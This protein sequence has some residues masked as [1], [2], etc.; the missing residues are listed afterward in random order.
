MTYK[1]IVAHTINGVIGKAGTMPW[2]LPTD[3]AYFRRVTEGNVVVMGRKTF[4]S[5]GRPLPNRRNIVMTRSPQFQGE[6]IETVHGEEELEALLAPV[7]AKQSV[8][9][10]GG[11]TIYARFIDE[12]S[13]IHLTLIEAVID[14]DAFFPRLRGDWRVQRVEHHQTKPDRPLRGPWYPHCIYRLTRA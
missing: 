2:H 9:I 10:I 6:G 7:A 8:Y 11:E 5:I 1:L 4:Q 14:G 3:L 12:A 13:E